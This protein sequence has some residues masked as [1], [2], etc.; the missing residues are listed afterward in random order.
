MQR[1]ECAICSRLSC[2]VHHKAVIRYGKLIWLPTLGLQVQD[3][4]GSGCKAG[5]LNKWWKYARRCWYNHD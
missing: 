2:A 5:M 1:N 3:D 4:E